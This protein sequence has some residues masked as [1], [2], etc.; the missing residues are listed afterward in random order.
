LRKCA[1]SIPSGTE[2]HDQDGNLVAKNVPI[3][4]KRLGAFAAAL[5]TRSTP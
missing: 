5:L 4:S 3:F 2:T 1:L